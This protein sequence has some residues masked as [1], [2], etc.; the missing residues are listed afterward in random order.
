MDVEKRN[1]LISIV[2]LVVII[3]LA[4]YLYDSIVTPYQEVIKQ[5][6]MTERVHHQMGNIRDAL[7]R[8]ER[9][10]DEFP[11]SKG[12]L[13]SLVAYLKTDSL[14]KIQGDSLY[15]PLDKNKSYNPDSLIYSVRPPHNRFEYALN[16]TLR[17]QIYLL[18]DPDTEDKVGSLKKTTLRNAGS[19]E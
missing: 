8:Y 9:E 3:G 5:E 6:K 14:M 11:P 7:I 12:G 19:W 4:Y 18:K 15:Q 2:L 17:P 10:S 13:D 1:R 16:D